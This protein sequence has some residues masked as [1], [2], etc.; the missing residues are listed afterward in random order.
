MQKCL[1]VCDNKRASTIAFPALGAGILKY[2]LKVVAKVMI[3]TVQNYYQTNTKT[4][5]KE[6]KFVMYTDDVYKEFECILSQYSEPVVT[7]SIVDSSIPAL[8]ASN[9]L[10]RLP[11]SA[12]VPTAVDSSTLFNEE[13]LTSISNNYSV[14]ATSV[15]APIKICSGKLLNEKV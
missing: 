14:T 3:N 4:C 11:S 2:P 6:V 12:T 5:I 9:H 10:E 13:S 1:Q 15:K 8:F 7:S